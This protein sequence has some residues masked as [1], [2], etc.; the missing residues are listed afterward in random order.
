MRHSH[1]RAQRC[2]HILHCCADA[3]LLVSATARKTG[4]GPL[5]AMTRTSSRITKSVDP[6]VAVMHA[7]C[8]LRKS[9]QFVLFYGCLTSGCFSLCVVYH[10]CIVVINITPMACPLLVPSHVITQ[11][12]VRTP[13]IKT[14]IHK[15]RKK[16]SSEHVM[17]ECCS[18]IPYS[19]L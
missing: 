7:T 19:L 16:R 11:S 17:A 2:L 6:C 14:I 12:M 3:C 8:I 9:Q 15:Q 5:G 13:V 1:T 4:R 18:C 10:E